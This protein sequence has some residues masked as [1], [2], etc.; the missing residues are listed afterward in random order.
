MM[1][2]PFSKWNEGLE[3][4]YALEY[5]DPDQSTTPFRRKRS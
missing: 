2:L 3:D 4:A 1:V 5:K